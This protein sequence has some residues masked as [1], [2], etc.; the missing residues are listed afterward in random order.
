MEENQKQTFERKKFAY[1]FAIML[2]DYSQILYCTHSSC[3]MAA[4]GGQ[5]AAPVIGF[6]WLKR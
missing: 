3:T 4:N 5:M 1:Y 2:P 6:F